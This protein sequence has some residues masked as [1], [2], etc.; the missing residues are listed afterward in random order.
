[1]AAFDCLHYAQYEGGDH[2]IIVGR[3]VAMEHDVEGEPLC[4]RGRSGAGRR[5]RLMGSKRR[6]RSRAYGRLEQLVC[7]GSGCASTRWARPLVPRAT[8]TPLPAGRFAL[9]EDR[10]NLNRHACRASPLPSRL[11]EPSVGSAHDAGTCVLIV[12]ARPPTRWP[13]TDR[14]GD[15]PRRAAAARR[16]GASSRSLLDFRVKA[17]TA[18]ASRSRPGSTSRSWTSTGANAPTSSLSTLA[19][20]S[21][22]IEC[23]LDST[24]TRTIMGRA[25][26]GPG[27][28]LEVLRPAHARRPSRWCRTPAA[29][30]TPSA[31]PAP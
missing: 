29:G 28:V 3:V 6:R 17:A 30:T 18:D 19:S 26:P 7:A 9:P 13:A 2:L 23:G 31:S 11:F 14:G 4:S 15:R 5:D 20:S 12:P 24:A 8:P 16:A 27:P 1:M 22:G 21:D 25:Y 10:A